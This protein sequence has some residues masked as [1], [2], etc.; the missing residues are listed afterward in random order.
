M[1][2]YFD[3]IKNKILCKKRCS[4]PAEF[5]RKNYSHTLARLK[6]HQFRIPQLSRNRTRVKVYKDD[7]NDKERWRKRTQSS[8]SSTKNR[9]RFF[10]KNQNFIGQN[11]KL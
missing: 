4:T 5:L 3:I 2:S 1:E 6:A 10:S 9:G 8:P 7:L 11:R